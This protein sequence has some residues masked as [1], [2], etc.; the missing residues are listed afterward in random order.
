MHTITIG[1]HKILIPG[2]WNELTAEQLIQMAK[3]IN[4][5]I[6]LEEIKVK[7][8]FIF[9]GIK[10]V[11]QPSVLVDGKEFFWI[12]HQK[13]KFLVSAHSLAHISSPFLNFFTEINENEWIIKPTITR[14]LLPIV[15]VGKVKLHGPADGL[16]NITFRE[17]IFAETALNQLIAAN[18]TTQLNQLIGILY[19]PFG[20]IK[21]G[22]LAYTG[23]VREKFNDNNMD[24][25]AKLIASMPKELKRAILWYYKG[26]KQHLSTLFPLVFSEGSATSKSTFEVFMTIVDDIANNQ[27]AEHER[28]LDVLLYSALQSLNNRIEKSLRHVEV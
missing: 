25:Q 18:D 1:T 17:F 22:T 6:G 16:S 26:C 28:I 5:N 12:R 15:E 11:Q 13:R 24:E 27:P 21:Q 8:L 7:M 14:Q 10:V 20:K 19:R 23:D 4:G 2:C 9:T 3:L